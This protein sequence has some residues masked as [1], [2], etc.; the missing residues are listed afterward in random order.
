ME[1][2]EMMPSQHRTSQLP[3]TIL[4]GFLGAG[5][6]TLLNR[7]LKEAPEKLAVLVN[8][9]AAINVD[10]EL[11][12]SSSAERISLS[13]GCVCC[14]IKD[15]LLA[16]VLA[17]ADPA[18]G[19]D[20]IVLETSGVANPMSIAEAFLS[21]AI[22]GRLRVDATICLVDAE[23][24]LDL[25]YTSSELAIDQAAVA[26]LALLNKCDLVD[27]ETLVEIE[28][29]LWGAL[30]NMRIVRTT[31]A[32]VPWAVLSD[33]RTAG[34]ELG[35]SGPAI[36]ARAHS[37]AQEVSAHSHAHEAHDH[38]DDYASWSWTGT[39]ETE[40]A[41]RTIIRKLP[42]SIIRGKGIVKFLDT[43]GERGVFQL[44][45]KRSTL[46][47]EPH[48]GEQ[49]DSRI[50]FI[51]LRRRFRPSAMDELFVSNGRMTQEQI[52]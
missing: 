19:F 45:G 28:R 52:S 50:V 30:P 21:P 44:V 47:I 26:D 5:K 12:E 20:R 4:F 9:F 40:Q 32:N 46:E 48:A 51:G 33:L 38:E 11:V 1:D 35:R 39:F 23:Q 14:T 49:T 22:A 2:H 7:L 36:A 13:N 37:H 3:V 6:T 41:F 27:E 34:A 24:F 15:D 17:L 18:Q 25:D 42:N 43:P 29:V 31:M 8:D 10:I 16:A